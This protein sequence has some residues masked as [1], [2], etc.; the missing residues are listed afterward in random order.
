MYIRRY[1]N[2]KINGWMS[3]TLRAS[4]SIAGKLTLCVS[5]LTGEDGKSSF[6]AYV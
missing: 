6:L 2:D 4:S 3:S 1:L 5:M